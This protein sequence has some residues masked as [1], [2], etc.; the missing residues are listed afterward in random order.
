MKELTQPLKIVPDT[1]LVY[2][3]NKEYTLKHR[4]PVRRGL[5]YFEVDII[6]MKAKP[7]KIRK[8]VVVGIDM[9]PIYKRKAVFNPDVVYVW[10]LN[11]FNALRKV[12]RDFNAFVA[13]RS[14]V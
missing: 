11:E 6:N 14:K 2:A 4:E 7:V 9:K 12:Q 1:Q 13:S 3:F 8:E 10:A 5:I